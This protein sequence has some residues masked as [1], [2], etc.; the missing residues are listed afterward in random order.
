MCAELALLVVRSF[1]SVMQKDADGNRTEEE[2][3]SFKRGL[4]AMRSLYGSLAGTAVLLQC[5]VSPRPDALLAEDD[6]WNPTP[7]DA[8]GWTN[9]EAGVARVV[10]AHMRRVASQLARQGR[11][12]PETIERAQSRPKLVDITNAE[13]VPLDETADADSAAAITVQLRTIIIKIEKANFTS[14]YDRAIVQQMLQVLEWTMLVAEEAVLSRRGASAALTESRV[15]A[16]R[17][18]GWWRGLAWRSNGQES[19]QIEMLG[20]E[21]QSHGG[22]E[23]VR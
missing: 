2:T 9:F 3:E 22:H 16:G 7:Y 10:A 4:K 13:A 23:I 18:V 17:W 19:A 14:G 8:R 12:I 5:N 6:V 15:S 11:P 1:C 20:R 21:A